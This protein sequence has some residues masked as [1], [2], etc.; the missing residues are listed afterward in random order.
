MS[1]VEIQAAENRAAGE[2]ERRLRPIVTIQD[3]RAF[4][5]R[6]IA[7]L[8]AEGW[9]PPLRPNPGW[10]QHA[11]QPGAGPNDDWR[12]AK[13]ALLRDTQGGSDGA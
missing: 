5:E 2:L 6:F 9:R 13:E 11:A 7:D 10:K 3:V 12:A 8:R 1:D 4:A